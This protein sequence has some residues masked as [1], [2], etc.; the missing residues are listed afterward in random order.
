M[1]AVWVGSS[2]IYTINVGL[3]NSTPFRMV[4]RTAFRICNGHKVENVGRGMNS[5]VVTFPE[6][7]SRR[8]VPS[9]LSILKSCPANVASQGHIT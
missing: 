3:G 6:G 1:R 5:A 8:D 4:W 7:L 9:G 2:F